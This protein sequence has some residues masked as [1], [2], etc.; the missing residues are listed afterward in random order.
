MR[1][2]LAVV[3]ATA[4]T[5]ARLSRSPRPIFLRPN[6]SWDHRPFRARWT[7][8][9]RSPTLLMTVGR[10]SDLVP[11]EADHGGEDA[12]DR[13]EDP[14]GWSEGGA[15]ERGQPPGD[16]RSGRQSRQPPMASPATTAPRAPRT[17]HPRAGPP[18]ADGASAVGV[19]VVP[20][21]RSG[22]SRSARS[23]RSGASRASGGG[24]ARPS[25][26]GP[27]GRCRRARPPR[28]R[29]PARR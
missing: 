2:T 27:S 18:A 26:R 21:G 11:R 24:R 29:R 16:A 9:Q 13:S 6:Y 25:G 14:V 15:L 3:T 7:A 10:G 4:A 28:G 23:A 8:I 12:P 1:P 5:G 17:D 22:P 20:P 19:T